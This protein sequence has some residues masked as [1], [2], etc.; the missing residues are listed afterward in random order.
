MILAEEVV[1]VVEA[2]TEVEVELDTEVAAADVE[3]DVAAV[4]VI[5]MWPEVIALKSGK[6]FPQKREREYSRLE[7][8]IEAVAVDIT[9][10]VGIRRISPL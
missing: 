7:R 5:I 10:A 1:L 2:F 3:A 8:E 6:L 9:K 4:A